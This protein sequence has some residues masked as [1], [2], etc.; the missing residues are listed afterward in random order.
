MDGVGEHQLA[1]HCLGQF[2]NGQRICDSVSGSEYD[3]IG[4]LIND[5]GRGPIGNRQPK[6]LFHKWN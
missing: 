1:Q 3:R 6:L 2:R 5:A 4:A